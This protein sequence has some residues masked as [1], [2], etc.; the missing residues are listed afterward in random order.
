MYIKKKQTKMN[1]PLRDHAKTYIASAFEDTVLEQQAQ[2]QEQ[3]QEQPQYLD[4]FKISKYIER[5]VYNYS[6]REAT[7]RKVVKQWINPLFK[8]LYKDRLRSVG[9]N[10]RKH[11]A[12]RELITSKQIRPHEVAFMTHQEM[13]P[14]R[15]ITALALKKM[16]D[17]NKYS[18]KLEASTD[19]YTCRKCKGKECTYYQMQ[20][21]SADEPMTTFVACITC[22]N[23]WKC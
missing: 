15:W 11:A 10:L 16:R 12:L 5:G 6:I 4:K 22:G 17:E 8:H 1:E 3:E 2:E 13:E 23:Q 19:S 14:K 7:N 18:Q 9:I 21:R 20:T